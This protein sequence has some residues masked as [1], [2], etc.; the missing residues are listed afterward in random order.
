M[1]GGAG[2]GRS[3]LAPARGEGWRSAPRAAADARA[4]EIAP[5]L[6]SLRL[7]L[8]YL[9]PAVVNCYLVALEEGWWLIDCGSHLPP[10]IDSLEHALGGAGVELSQVRRLLCTHSHSDHAAL[11][12]I[13]IERS[14][15]RYLR[16]A[17]A[18]VATDVL[19]D[20]SVTLER[21]R[22]LGR[23]AGVPA[24]ELDGWVDNLLEGDCTH[25]RPAA[26]QTVVDGDLL[27]SAVGD[28]LVIEAG[29]HSPSQVVLHN[30][31]HGWLIC[32]DLA[33]PGVA[34]YLECGWTEDPFEEHLTALTRCA[35]L[36]VSLLLPGH[37]RPDPNAR[38]RLLETRA[39]MEAHAEHVLALLGSARRTPF[40]IAVEL[41][42]PE[43]DAD[44]CQAALATVVAVLEHFER[45]GAVAS[46]SDAAGVQRFE[47]VAQAPVAAPAAA[48]AA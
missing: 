6:W 38:K 44:L 18:D 45:L 22:E 39:V 12:S 43:V 20:P 41:L 28:W 3:L 35:E 9:A 24:G 21:R 37:G 33:F 36:P 16:G 46:S 14:G 48:P 40:E 19:R 5:G 11:A 27:A 29:G 47:R 1:A 26:D 15:C 34:P 31:Q 4:N 25:P 30:A 2:D 13:V 32:A 8:P 10:G 42:T 17:G 7:P 23:R